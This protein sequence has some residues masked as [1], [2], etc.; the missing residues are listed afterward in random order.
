MHTGHLVPSEERTRITDIIRKGTELARVIGRARILLKLD[1]GE[2]LTRIAEDALVCE[3]TVKRI[4]ARYNGGGLD[5][6]LYD[7][8]RPGQPKKLNSKAEA[9][10]VALACGDPPNGR[11]RWTLLLL[12]ERMIKDKKVDTISDVCILEYLNARKIK[13]WRE[14]NVVR[15]S[16]HSRVYD[17]HGGRALPV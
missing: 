14:K 10:L 3:K 7:L 6:A 8:P 4:R 16:Y 13:P 15:S 2:R 9:H 12:K 17:T 5:R 11:D 1:N